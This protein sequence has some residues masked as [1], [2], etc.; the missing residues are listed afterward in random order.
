MN[1]AVR[2]S[3]RPGDFKP[4]NGG[5]PPE[6]MGM[7]R[8]LGLKPED[9]KGAD[10]YWKMLD[11]LSTSDP[12]QYDALVAQS[13]EHVEEM[14]K[15]REAGGGGGGGPRKGHLMP[16]PGF[17]VKARRKYGGGKVMV[18]CCAHRA[19]AAP[20]DQ[21]GKAVGEGYGAERRSAPGLQIP[22]GVSEP[23]ACAV[24]GDDDGG[25]AS[26]TAIDVLFHPWRRTA[27]W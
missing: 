6:F 7:A 1:T 8:Q 17:V 9:L 16:E 11:D 19:L 12:A 13:S 5:L 23:R 14:K 21:F 25:A 27:T 3:A 2:Q 10:K 24:G 18:N 26:G 4:K 22:M 20:I 15:E